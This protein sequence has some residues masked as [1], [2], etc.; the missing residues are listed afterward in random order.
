MTF[1]SHNVHPMFVTKTALTC[2]QPGIEHPIPA[3]YLDIF[4]AL[5]GMKITYS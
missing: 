5:H 3:K 4:H 2:L 1:L